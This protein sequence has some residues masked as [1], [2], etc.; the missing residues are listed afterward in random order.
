M[1]KTS[2]WYHDLDESTTVMVNL[3]QVVMPYIEFI[4]DNNITNKFPS[5]SKGYTDMNPYLSSEHDHQIILDK[6]ET[7]EDINHNEYVDDK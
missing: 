7:R 1:R 3:K 4:Q 5:S 6:I 2:Y